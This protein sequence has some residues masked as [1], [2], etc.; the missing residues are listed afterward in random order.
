MKHVADT[1]DHADEIDPAQLGAWMNGALG[2]E[3]GEGGLTLQR[4]RGGH[5]NRTY[6]VMA[7]A[8]RWV[9][10]LPPT[11]A[12]AQG[13]HDVSRECRVLSAVAPE[14]PLAP[15]VVATEDDSAVLGAPASA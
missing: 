9:L 11:G 6:G 12:V 4:F 15:R 8:G 7:N 13:A 2:V 1:P 10:R 14:L 5:S 3:P